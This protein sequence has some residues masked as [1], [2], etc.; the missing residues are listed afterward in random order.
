MRRL[1]GLIGVLVVTGGCGDHTGPELATCVLPRPEGRVLTVSLTPGI[2]CELVPADVEMFELVPSNESAKYLAVIQSGSQAPE[3]SVSLK[4]EVSA[5][6]RAT[7]NEPSSLAMP[8]PPRIDD[9][10]ED[11]ERA[12]RAELLFRANARQALINVKPLR[13]GDA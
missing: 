4:I 3:S 5:E 8:G 1:L 11:M 12:S 6:E 7:G 2:I 9:Q 13:H 10:A